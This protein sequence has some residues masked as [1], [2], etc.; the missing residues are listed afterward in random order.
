MRKDHQSNK[1][2]QG[3]GSGQDSA[4]RS[5][6]GRECKEKKERYTITVNYKKKFK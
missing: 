1:L 6:P 5:V 2:T 4:H 3:S